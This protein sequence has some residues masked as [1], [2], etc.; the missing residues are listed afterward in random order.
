MH[1][2]W[3]VDVQMIAFFRLCVRNCVYVQLSIS[4]MAHCSQLDGVRDIPVFVFH[5]QTMSYYG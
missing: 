4:S 3:S 2:K 5:V 1:R